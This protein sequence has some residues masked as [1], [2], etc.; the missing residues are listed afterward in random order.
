MKDIYKPRPSQVAALAE[1]LWIHQ[2]DK[3]EADRVFELAEE[4]LLLKMKYLREV[5]DGQP[6]MENDYDIQ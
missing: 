1:Q 4:F 6:S 5:N 3:F 2:C